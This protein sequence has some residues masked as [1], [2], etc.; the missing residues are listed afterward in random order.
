M[1]YRG[2]V[3]LVLGTM[4]AVLLLW[5]GSGYVLACTADAFVTSDLVAIAPEVSGTIESVTVADNQPVL[6]GTLLAT[7]DPRPFQLALAQRRAQRD[8]A[9]AQI[10]VDENGVAAAQ[11]ELD[12]AVATERLANETLARVRPLT[13][14]GDISR[15]SLDDAI[16][17]QQTAQAAVAA[18]AA[19]FGRARQLLKVHEAAIATAEAGIALAQYDLDRTRI[20]APVDGSIVSLTLRAGDRASTGVPLIGMVDDAAWRIIANYRESLLRHLSVGQS[21]W[22]WLDAYPWHLHRARIQGIARGIS[23]EPGVRDLLPYVAPTTDWI[24]LERRFP[25]T[26]L[27]DNAEAKQLL[28]MGADARA[29]VIY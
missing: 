6:R 15:Q 11:A 3:G 22:V 20:L 17:H 21:A 16:S 23:R 19:A 1:G 7:I 13:E 14:R 28:H 29:L 9:A 8:Q 10:P 18:A 25:V 12:A 26:L 24:R 4:L 27:L 2:Q 5:W